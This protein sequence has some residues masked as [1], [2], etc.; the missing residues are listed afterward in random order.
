MTEG[1][2]G[3]VEAHFHGLWGASHYVGDFGQRLVFELGQDDG[4]S[5]V[6]GEGG[7]GV[8][9]GVGTFV[10]FQGFSGRM[11]GI[12]ERS[13]GLGLGIV[14]GIFQGRFGVALA[15][16]QAVTREIGRDREEPCLERTLEIEPGTVGMN[17]NEGFLGEVGGI[18][19]LT[20]DTSEV[21]EEGPTVTI[22]EAVESA[23]FVGNQPFHV[24]A[25]NLRPRLTHA[26]EHG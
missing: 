2:A 4:E 13:A 19:G 10:L 22:D 8:P 7:D 20:K 12:G 3:A 1:M 5:K 17:A 15:P 16:A 11:G 21:R 9:H 24:D 6:V 26:G 23:G 14:A 18:L 25:V